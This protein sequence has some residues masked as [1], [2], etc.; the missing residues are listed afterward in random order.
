MSAKYVTTALC[1]GVIGLAGMSPVIAEEHA[2]D[3]GSGSSQ[4]GGSSGSGASSGSGSSGSGSGSD[5]AQTQSGDSGQKMSAAQGMEL[6]GQTIQGANGDELGEVSNVIADQNGEVVAVVMDS[7]GIL[8]LGG[9]SWRVGWDRIRVDQGAAKGGGET[10]GTGSGE[11]GG[12][13]Q[14]AQRGQVLSIGLTSDQV[15]QQLPRYEGQEGGDQSGS[16][17]SGSGS[18]SGESGSSSQ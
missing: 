2:S 18:S 4:D 12:S 16:A 8:G 13:G 11:S 5:T 9:S 3:N 15:E 14:S 1:A 17:S 6:V 7:G 10:G